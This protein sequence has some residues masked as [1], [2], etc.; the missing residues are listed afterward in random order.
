VF[1]DVA[2][3]PKPNYQKGYQMDRPILVAL[4]RGRRTALTVALAAVLLAVFASVA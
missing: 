4:S 3:H 1:R 2:D